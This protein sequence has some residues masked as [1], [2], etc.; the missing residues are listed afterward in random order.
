MPVSNASRLEPDRLGR[1]G[2]EARTLEGTG[3]VCSFLF[4]PRL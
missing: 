2:Y 1:S 3:S 4:T